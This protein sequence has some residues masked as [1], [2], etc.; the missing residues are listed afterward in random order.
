M[1]AV[2]SMALLVVAYPVA[3][4]WRD[5]LSA[6]LAQSLRSDA[7]IWLPGRQLMVPARLA[8]GA[9]IQRGR[10][11]CRSAGDVAKSL[12]A[13]ASH[14]LRSPLARIQMQLEL[15][16][17][18]SSVDIRND[19]RREIGELDALVE[20]ILLSSRLQS[21]HR[22]ALKRRGRAAGPLLLEEAARV[23]IAIDGQLVAVHGDQRLLRRVIRNMVENAV[24]YSGARQTWKSRWP[25]DGIAPLS[26]C[27]T[28]GLAYLKPSGSGS[29]SRSTGRRVPA[30]GRAVSAWV[31]RSPVRSR[32]SMAAN[33]SACN[34]RRWRH[35]RLCLADRAGDH[36][37]RSEIKALRA[38]L[39]VLI[40][41][42]RYT[43]APPLRARRACSP[44][45]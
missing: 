5:A 34:G 25:R 31:Y 38:F 28:V 1:M 37:N 21:D 18:R 2:I 20:E 7:A 8:N 15:F 35:F 33:C 32:T 39:A 17:E 13:N 36:K 29:S 11:A 6:S 16:G 14:E 30:K 40:A 10:R 24:R 44:P 43:A 9:L 42:P 26:T 12:L 22:P 3:R 45:L 27:L 41:A 4:G 23:G 19:I